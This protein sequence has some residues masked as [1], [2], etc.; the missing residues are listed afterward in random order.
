MKKFHIYGFNFRW[1]SDLYKADGIKPMAHRRFYASSVLNKDGNLWVLGG[2][3]EDKASDTTE[4]YEYRPKGEGTWRTGPP[5]PDDYRDTGIESHCTVRY[6]SSFN[7]YIYIYMY[8]YI[9]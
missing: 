8:I 9:K 7:L 5:L 4:V 6:I 1:K 2:T 3:A